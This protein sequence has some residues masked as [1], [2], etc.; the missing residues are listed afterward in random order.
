M[1]VWYRTATSAQVPVPL[2]VIIGWMQSQQKHVAVYGTL[3]AGQLH[4][5]VVSVRPEP[6]NLWVPCRARSLARRLLDELRDELGRSGPRPVAFASFSGAAKACYVAVLHL[7]AQDASYSAVKANLVGEL[8]D[9]G[10]IDFISRAGVMFLAPSG[11]PRLQRAGVSAL[12]TALDAVWGPEF[13]R[14]R[15]EFWAAITR[16]LPPTCPVLILHSEDDTLSPPAFIQAFEAELRRN[17]RSSVRRVCWQESEHVA[18]LR[19]HPDEY[20]AAVKQWLEDCARCWHDTSTQ[21]AALPGA[22]SR[23]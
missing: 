15:R 18:H 20:T 3:F 13:E 4:A 16:S 12:A 11:A 23:L 6:L 19:K 7:L 14:Q 5:D 17:G 10:P 2:V 8:Y 9:S 21:G 1:F 22:M